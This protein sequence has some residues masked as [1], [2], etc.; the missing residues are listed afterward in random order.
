M[1]YLVGTDTV[2]VDR[3]E[4]SYPVQVNVIVFITHAEY[5]KIW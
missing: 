3:L 5:S 1:V 4:N 2:Y